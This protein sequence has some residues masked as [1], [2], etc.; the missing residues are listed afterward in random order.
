MDAMFHVKGILIVLF[1][2]FCVASKASHG[3]G[4]IAPR[5]TIHMK[6]SIIDPLVI[7]CKSKDDDLGTQEIPYGGSYKIS[8]KAHISGRTLFW[9][10][11]FWKGAKRGVFNAYDEKNTRWYDNCFNNLGCNCEWILQPNGP[12]YLLKSQPLC[13]PWRQQLVE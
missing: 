11:L 9:C 6:N 10:D 1:L 7:H 3:C 4:L 13:M 2:S 8:F 5:F 12:C